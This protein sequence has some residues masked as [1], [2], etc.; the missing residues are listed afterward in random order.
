MSNSSPPSL[1]SSPSHA[2]PSPLLAATVLAL[3]LGVQPVTT[4]LMLPALPLLATDLAA[5]MASVQLT[6]SAL[7]LAFGIAQL[8]WGPLSD[9]F[10]RR[11]VLLAGLGLYVL[12]SIGCALAGSIVQVVAWRIVQGAALS[13][14]VVCARAMV[15]DLY[16]PHEGALVMAKALS[17]LGLIAISAPLTG[18]ALGA[19]FGWRAEP[20]LMALVGALL[21]VLILRRWPETLQH[22]RP[23]ATQ[24]GPLLEQTAALLRHPTFR[25]WALLVCC[26]YGGLFVFLAGAGFVMI[27]VLGLTPLAAGAVMSTTSLA[28]IAGTF[29]CRYW[30]RLHGLTGAVQRGAGFSLA[31]SVLMA[32]LA[33]TDLRAVW[34]VM[35][36]TWLYAM[37][38]GIHQPCGQ[39]GAVG[40]FPHAAGQASALAGFVLSLG[41]FGVGL[42]LGQALD[43]TVGPLAAGMS[44]GAGL[45][46]LVAWTLV[47]RHGAPASQPLGAPAAAV[48]QR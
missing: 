20:A 23:N 2:R 31:A 34:A 24:I 10:G 14:P 46:A 17:G 42:W 12:S 47:R 1:P 32:A 33:L 5:P 29:M 22:R 30:L 45:T 43:G 16:E 26:T 21:A 36:P 9:R 37:G 18:G 13:V 11:P 48:A 28:Y 19:I 27:S 25:A 7:I 39:A 3:L 35:L 41:A 38:H 6:M 40:P 15:R 8:V 44:A 4:D